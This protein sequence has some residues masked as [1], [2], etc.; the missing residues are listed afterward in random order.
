M[1]CIFCRD[2]VSVRRGNYIKGKSNN[3]SENSKPGKH[4]E[5]D[6]KKSDNIWQVLRTP[7]VFIIKPYVFARFQNVRDIKIER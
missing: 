3:L 5:V 6:I 1:N 4:N 2:L 7:P